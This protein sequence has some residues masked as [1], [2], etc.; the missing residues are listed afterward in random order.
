MTTDKR[1][2]IQIL[3]RCRW[4]GKLF[5]IIMISEVRPEPWTEVEG[6][7]ETGDL[8]DWGINMCR[9]E[10]KRENAWKK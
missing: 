2:V 1:D 5:M 3:G 7:V 10:G 4:S 8:P 6:G 9:P